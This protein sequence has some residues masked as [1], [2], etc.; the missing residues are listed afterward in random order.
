M[1]LN[2]NQMDYG[3]NLWANI[4]KKKKRF[5]K[6][7]SPIENRASKQRDKNYLSQGRVIG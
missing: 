2:N 7:K 3:E 6:G 4:W 1:H 5:F